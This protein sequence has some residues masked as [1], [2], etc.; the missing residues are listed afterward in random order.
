MTKGSA[1][2]AARVFAANPFNVVEVRHDACELLR[3]P[4]ACRSGSAGSSPPGGGS[5][6]VLPKRWNQGNEPARRSLSKHAGAVESNAPCQAYL[7]GDDC[8]GL[9]L[10]IV[11]PTVEVELP[12]QPTA[13]TFASAERTPPTAGVR[14]ESK[15]SSRDSRYVWSPLVFRKLIIDVPCRMKIFFT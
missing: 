11:R 1:L 13:H 10:R 8:I 2:A 15:L 12:P 3:R 5:V 7:F 4:G 14:A 6:R 9:V